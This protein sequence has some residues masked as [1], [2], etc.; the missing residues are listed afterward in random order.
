MGLP[1]NPWLLRTLDFLSHLCEIWDVAFIQINR[2][3]LMH[4]SA[5]SLV[6]IMTHSIDRQW[7]RAAA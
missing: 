3:I 4:H 1:D 5:T 6:G 2:W 7:Q